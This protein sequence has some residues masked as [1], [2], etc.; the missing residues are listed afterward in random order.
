MNTSLLIPRM[1]FAL[2][3]VRKMP[4]LRRQCP[5][6]FDLRLRLAQQGGQVGGLGEASPGRVG[7][8]FSTPQRRTMMSVEL[9]HKFDAV[10]RHDLIDLHRLRGGDGCA[11]VVI[12]AEHRGFSVATQLRQRVDIAD[13]I[14]RL[15][16]VS[17]EDGLAQMGLCLMP[18]KPL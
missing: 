5:V 18:S 9:M 10:L 6:R 16:T 14:P 1:R 7:N 4:P 11:A 17:I 13:L 2:S 15:G 8:V 12:Q 3:V